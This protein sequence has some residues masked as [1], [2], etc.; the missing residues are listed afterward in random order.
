VRVDGDR[1][2]D[3]VFVAIYDE[4]VRFWLNFWFMLV[5][6]GLTWF[7]RLVFYWYVRFMHFILN[8]PPI[9][10]ALCL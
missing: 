5:C 6:R 9:Y 8:I 7:W 3:F 10:G 4:V 2:L 1:C